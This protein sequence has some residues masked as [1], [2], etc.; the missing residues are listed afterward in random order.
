MAPY[1]V[2]VNLHFISLNWEIIF[3][4]QNKIPLA[5]NSFLR[6]PPK[7]YIGI[8]VHLSFLEVDV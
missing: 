5:E 1:F 2:V 7:G 6:L 8:F 3:E 4:Y